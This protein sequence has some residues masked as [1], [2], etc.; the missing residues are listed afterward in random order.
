MRTAIRKHIME[1]L[2][3]ISSDA[4]NFEHQLDYDQV[5]IDEAVERALM[6]KR[7]ISELTEFVCQHKI[8]LIA[9]KS[10]EIEEIESVD[11][12][13]ITDCLKNTFTMEIDK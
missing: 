8:D 4:I 2:D 1:K 5:P 12:I 10:Q 13:D 7:L 3:R 9:E 11:E 6:L